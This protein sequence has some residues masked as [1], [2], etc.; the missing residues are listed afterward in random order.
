MT[1]KQTLEKQKI[2]LYAKNKNPDSSP[3]TE[4][5]ERNDRDC[6]ANIIQIAQLR[7]D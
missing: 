2:T 4:S 5:W 3:V 7:M 6:T 1:T